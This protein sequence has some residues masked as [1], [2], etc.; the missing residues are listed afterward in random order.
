ML[1]CDE[2]ADVEG[3]WL[4]YANQTIADYG[5]GW[6]WMIELQSEFED[7]VIHNVLGSLKTQLRLNRVTDCERIRR[8]QEIDS[9]LEYVNQIRRN[10]EIAL[11]SFSRGR[12]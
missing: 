9:W 7:R 8:C 1:R 11:L 10:Y 6:C 2:N 12:I 4:E 5:M 3:L